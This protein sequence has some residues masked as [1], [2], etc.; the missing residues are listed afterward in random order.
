MPVVGTATDESMSNPRLSPDG[1]KIAFDWNWPKPDF[2]GTIAVVNATGGTP[3]YITPDDA[4]VGLFAQPSWHPDGTKVIYIY[5]PDSI[6]TNGGRIEVVDITGSGTPTVLWTPDVQS[7]QRE[8]A[9]RPHY[10]PDG[11][12][13]AFI[14]NV[15]DGGGGD[16][17]RQGLWVMDSDGSND[18]LIDAFDTT[19][20]NG[21][22]G[23][24]GTQLAW[25]NDG[26]MIA[27]SN[28]GFATLARDIYRIAPDGTGKTKLNNGTAAGGLCRIGHD[29]W[30]A[31]D[32][33]VIMA[34]SF[35]LWLLSADGATQTQ[36]TSGTAFTAGGAN[37][38]NGYRNPS[39]DR[40]Y[41]IHDNDPPI[42]SSV[43]VDGSDYRVDADMSAVTS[44]FV[45]GDGFEWS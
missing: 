16:Y 5:C 20:G 15:D 3:L 4:G 19:Q 2:S 37:F 45:S 27:Y 32:S 30:L 26:T 21:G 8:G 44:E 10:S 9:F 12:K 1:G 7:P 29:A 34:K 24:S 35:Y 18:A 39:D 33:A 40:I 36:L 42:V 28:G 17:T 11:T 25:S 38:S 22:Y 31:D 23:F 6:I 14:V 41:F 43:A 13:I